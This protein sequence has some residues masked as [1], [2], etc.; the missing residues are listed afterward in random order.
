VFPYLSFELIHG[1]LDCWRGLHSRD[2]ENQIIRSI[3]GS[4]QLV[5]KGLH[6]SVCVS[7]AKPD[8]H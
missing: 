2:T 5:P 6:A 8:V 7:R 3:A 4:T 1:L